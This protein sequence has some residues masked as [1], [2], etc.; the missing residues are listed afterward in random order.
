MDMHSHL[1]DDQIDGALTDQWTDDCEWRR[2]MSEVNRSKY[3]EQEKDGVRSSRHRQYHS[4]IARRRDK[5]NESVCPGSVG[6]K[7]KF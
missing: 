5:Y 7:C 4:R 6:T 1:N 3:L 2:R